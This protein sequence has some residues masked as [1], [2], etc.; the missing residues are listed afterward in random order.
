MGAVD[1]FLREI[2]LGKYAD[3]L[4]T[5]CRTLTELSRLRKHELVRIGMSSDEQRSYFNSFGLLQSRIK[6]EQEHSDPQ[7]SGHGRPPTSQRPVPGAGV[8][9]QITLSRDPR[10]NLM[11]RGARGVATPPTSGAPRSTRTP[12]QT[13][14]INAIRN[15]A[16]YDPQQQSGGR[17]RTSS[18]HAA[19]QPLSVEQQ[20]TQLKNCEDAVAKYLTPGVTDAFW[21]CKSVNHSDAQKRL[22]GQPEG[23]FV[24]RL[25]SKPQMIGCFV[26]SYKQ[27][28]T[29]NNRY[30][31]ST[32]QG[33]FCKGYDNTYFKSL[34]DLVDY[35]SSNED[36][37][38]RAFKCRLRV[39]EIKF[40]SQRKNNP[41]SPAPTGAV[42]PTFD[43][44]SSSNNTS[45]TPTPTNSGGS[46]GS[47]VLPRPSEPPPRPDR[48]ANDVQPGRV[49]IPSTP[50]VIEPAA[51][52]VIP[53]RQQSLPWFTD[54]TNAECIQA[55]ND[56]ADGAFVVRKSSTPKCYVLC[57]KDAGKATNYLIKNTPDGYHFAERVFSSVNDV[58]TTFLYS[59]FLAE[60]GDTM[61][62]GTPIP[63]CFPSEVA[64]D[65][66]GSVLSDESFW[67]DWKLEH[68]NIEKNEVLGAGEFGEV[69]GGL[70]KGSGEYDG[71]VAKVAIKQLKED[72]LAKDFLKEAQVMTNL[73]HI[74][75]VKI[76]GVTVAAP[77]LI[78]SELCEQGN[79][80]EYLMN[81]YDEKTL[82]SEVEM[83]G[84][85]HDIA[86]GM[87][88]LADQGYIHRDLAARNV[89]VSDD[90][91]KVADFGLARMVKEE[92]YVA[93]RNSKMP[94]R[95]T[96]PESILRGTFS[97]KSDVFS[98]AITLYEIVT[99][100]AIPYPGLTNKEVMEGVIKRQ[101]RNIQPEGCSDKMYELMEMCWK[102]DKD[103]RAS[104]EDI[105]NLLGELIKAHSNDDDLRGFDDA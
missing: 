93:D 79:L 91:C 77:R 14:P 1:D 21:Y 45:A 58:I 57:V 25:S 30:A 5:Q 71:M 26:L 32:P 65:G 7:F 88:H 11:N 40:N 43:N 37:A 41:R 46:G 74:N 80:K 4:K 70:L 69:W 87:E 9:A 24:I 15:I 31:M 48:R 64:E 38:V 100:G 39:A 90:L 63:G 59:P 20:M 81:R 75:L 89:L 62:L 16:L 3:S 12:Q 85:A 98:Y 92:I 22:E 94:I 53:P 50:R 42:A 27:R 49:K 13:P 51:A 19:Q 84:Y 97:T 55:V 18:Q 83:Y 54:K 78:V 2:H 17:P 6:E 8:K 52:P 60:S 104:F 56:G 73:D 101:Y 35:Y 28:G 95:W 23:G 47:K 86:K 103:D 96:A 66:H 99:H 29:V 36:A 76:Y 34:M 33:L 105:V 10:N 68:E 102:Q 67:Q 44:T 82:C 61:T 72:S